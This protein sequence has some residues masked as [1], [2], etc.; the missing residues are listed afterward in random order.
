MKIYKTI[1]EGHVTY[2][3]DKKNQIETEDDG[4][5]SCGVDAAC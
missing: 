2:R 1:V 5:G 4:N 3:D